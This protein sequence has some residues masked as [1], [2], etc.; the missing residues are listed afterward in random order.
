VS[1]EGAFDD[2]PALDS[3]SPV[4]V[5]AAH[6]PLAFDVERHAIE[7]ET[8]EPSIAVEVEPQLEPQLAHEPPGIEIEPCGVETGP[9]EALTVDVDVDVEASPEP[10]PEATQAVSQATLEAAMRGP[11]AEHENGESASPDATQ[12]IPR[13]LI[14]AAVT[15]AESGMSPQRAT[16]SDDEHPAADDWDPPE[17]LDQV[18]SRFNAAQ[19]VV[20]RTVR[21]EVGAGAVN[22]IRSCCAQVGGADGDAVAGVDMQ[23]DGSWDA[24]GL[25]NAVHALRLEDPWMRYQRLIDR[26]IDLL[27]QFIGESRVVDL[28]R[29]VAMVERSDAVR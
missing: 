8:A 1:M 6:E 16:S 17:D 3:V 26:E 20:Y 7:V 24:A 10:S 21:A 19:R 28:Q 22:F 14:E 5:E 23:A 29:E 13:E 15:G 9:V 27:R 18:I 4:G 2:A 25:R 12:V 11:L